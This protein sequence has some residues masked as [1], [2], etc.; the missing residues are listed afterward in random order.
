MRAV[1][2]VVP[3]TDADFDS[4]VLESEEPVLV[5]FSAPW[6]P[7]CRALEPVVED[8]ARVLAGR[9]RVCE[10]DVGSQAAVSAR[11]QIMVVPTLMVFHHGKVVCRES[12]LVS[13]DRILDLM[14]RTGVNGAVEA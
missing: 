14:A 11:F 3:V 8:I 6:C 4:V 10:L 1:A 5:E 9:A 2:G 12:G 7:P 13:R